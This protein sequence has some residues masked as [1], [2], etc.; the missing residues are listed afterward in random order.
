MI[1]REKQIVFNRNKKD[2][3]GLES[4]DTESIVHVNLFDLSRSCELSM[5]LSIVKWEEWAG[6]QR[7]LP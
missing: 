6:R 3:D 1:I 7:E 4:D 2:W 5:V